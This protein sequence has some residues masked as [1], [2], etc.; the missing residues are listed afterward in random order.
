MHVIFLL[1]FEWQQWYLCVISLGMIQIKDWDIDSL[2]IYYWD[3]KER[4]TKNLET[5]VIQW[6]LKKFMYWWKTRDLLHDYETAFFKF[7]F[8][9]NTRWAFVCM[10]HKWMKN[11]LVF[12]FLYETYNN[13]IRL[14]F[15][16]DINKKIKHFFWESQL[17]NITFL[18]LTHFQNE[19]HDFSQSIL[20][21][22]KK[23][24]RIVF[25]FTL[26]SFKINVEHLRTFTKKKRKDIEKYIN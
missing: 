23:N 11:H 10:Q 17:K 14:F 26:M 8:K 4:Q 19:S 5:G 2:V 15:P 7:K 25:C 16:S 21:C 18:K 1:W 6:L 3:R 9:D 20:W 13:S 24:E 12:F 22:N